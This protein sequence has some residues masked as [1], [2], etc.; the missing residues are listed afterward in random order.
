MTDIPIHS[1]LRSGKWI[2]MLNID[3]A[4]LSIDDI[5]YALG[6]L[7]RFNGQTNIYLSVAEH[8]INVANLLPDHLKLH[9]L[10]HDG[11]ESIM[12]DF[13]KPSVDAIASL[14]HEETG[15]Y[16]KNA[17]DRLK[18]KIDIAIYKALKIPFG[19]T[20]D[21]DEIASIKEADEKMLMMELDYAFHNTHQT[22][23]SVS[24][25]S[26]WKACVMREIYALEKIKTHGN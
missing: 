26:A 8:S 18:Y 2:D 19:P 14:M 11:H 16:F 5:A 21:Y 13:T 20:S 24:A 9:G 6:Q 23:D 1:R 4:D 17:I 7:C 15:V 10:L 3:P 12:G 25:G 22:M